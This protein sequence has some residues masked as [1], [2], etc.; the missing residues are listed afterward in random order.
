MKIVKNKTKTGKIVESGNT[1]NKQ[2]KTLEQIIFEFM[3]IRIASK[4]LANRY[5]IFIITVYSY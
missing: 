3:R 2:N 1:L 5:K 4:G